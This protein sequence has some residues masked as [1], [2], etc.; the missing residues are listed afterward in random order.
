[1]KR[2]DI[3]PNRT[4][5]FRPMHSRNA[6]VIPR[7]Q[8]H[9]IIPNHLIFV[10]VHIVDPRDMQ[11]HTGEER[12]PPGDGV[13]SHNRM[14]GREL[15]VFVQRG[16]SRGHDFVVSGFA[17][18]FEDWLG[19]GRGEGFHVFLEGGGHPVVSGSS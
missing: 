1:M 17:G 12:L 7:D 16:A 6:I 8:S 11:T 4:R 18:G 9:Y 14:Y 15:E 13:R 19:A 3:T 2:A 5:L 10:I